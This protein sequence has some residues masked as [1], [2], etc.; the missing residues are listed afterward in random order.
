ML[1]DAG[2]S[3][4]KGYG[5]LVGGFLDRNLKICYDECH[6]VIGSISESQGKEKVSHGR[7]RIYTYS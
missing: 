2:F 3:Y 5:K 6:N 4:K 7:E 1:Y